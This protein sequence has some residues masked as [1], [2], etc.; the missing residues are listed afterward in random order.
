MTRQLL[1]GLALRTAALLGSGVQCN[2]DGKG[3]AVCCT[4]STMQKQLNPPLHP[5]SNRKK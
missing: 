1:L 2:G 3:M 5:L 4:Y